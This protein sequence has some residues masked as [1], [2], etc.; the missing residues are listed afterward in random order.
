MLDWYEFM[1]RERQKELLRAAEKQCLIRGLRTA[2]GKEHSRLHGH[3]QKKTLGVSE[4]KSRIIQMERAY[5]L[6]CRIVT[7]VLI[8]ITVHPL[9]TKLLQER[10]AD[11]WLHSVLHLGSA[12]FG[13]YA[14]WYAT[15]IAPAKVFTWGIGL[16]Y[17][18]LG[19]YG[20]FTPGFLLHTSFAIPLGVA[21]NAFHLFLSVP[22]VVI[23]VL[24]IARALQ[25]TSSSR[26][27]YVD[28]S[29][30]QAAKQEAG[31]SEI[32]R[33]KEWNHVDIFG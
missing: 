16:L 14:G 22:A 9:T 23:V 21:D 20:W 25:A 19:V 10:F 18:V 29:E 28:L 12:L 27:P 15:N 2:R 3:S 32:Q 11:D 8:I 4:I 31:A 17:L 24:A 13:I 33:R 6:Y 30:G 5:R 26:R 7:V 1:A